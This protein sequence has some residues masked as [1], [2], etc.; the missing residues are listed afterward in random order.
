M[1]SSGDEPRGT[2]AAPATGGAAAASGSATAPLGPSLG[3]GPG[4]SAALS[5]KGGSDAGDQS[6]TPMDTPRPEPLLSGIARL[7]AEQT[8]LRAERKRVVKELKNA[9]KRRTR[10]RKR[11]RQLSDADLIAVL[12]M[13]ESTTGESVA[14]NSTG[15]TGTAASSAASAPANAGAPA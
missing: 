11:A 15:V 8:H 13:R 1:S 4:P 10:L 7:K 12:Q 2:T 3:A 5:G 6:A 14:G 9:E